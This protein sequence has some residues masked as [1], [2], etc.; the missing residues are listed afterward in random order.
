MKIE[1]TN[2]QEAYEQER[3]KCADLTDKIVILESEKEELQFKLDRIKNN[4]FWKM[5]KPARNVIHA[6]RR[7]KDRV[8][9]CGGPKGVV[10]KLA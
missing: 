7:I 3:E 2:F 4:T 5:T 8:S 9:N 1:E 6:S 10:K